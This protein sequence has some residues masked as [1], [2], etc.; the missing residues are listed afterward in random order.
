MLPAMFTR[1][2]DDPD[3]EAEQKKTQIAFPSLSDDRSGSMRT[4]LVVAIKDLRAAAG[5]LTFP[6][7]GEFAENG[8]LTVKWRI[9][10]L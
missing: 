1:T 8:T 7:K 10:P 6:M 9:A 2:T 3:K 5:T 4:P